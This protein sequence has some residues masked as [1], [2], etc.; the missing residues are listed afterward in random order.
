AGGVVVRRPDRLAARGPRRTG[1][2]A[3]L[4]GAPVVAE[5]D[6]RRR[7]DGRGGVAVR[8]GG[9]R[10]AAEWIPCGQRQRRG[11]ERT[12]DRGAV[13]KGMRSS[14]FQVPSSKPAG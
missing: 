13:Y 14:K 11:R 10:V 8:R 12:G 7:P 6:P 2:V 9:G 5:D 3:R 1:G 4:A